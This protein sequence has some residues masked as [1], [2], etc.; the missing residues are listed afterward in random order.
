MTLEQAL[1]YI[2]GGN[3]AASGP[4]YSSSLGLW[5]ALAGLLTI[6]LLVF[7]WRLGMVGRVFSLVCSGISIGVFVI[8]NP[9]P[10]PEQGT[11]FAHFNKCAEKICFIDVNPVG[12]DYDPDVQKLKLALVSGDM[13]LHET[14]Y[15]RND[16]TRFLGGDIGFH[17]LSTSCL[18]TE[19]TCDAFIALDMEPKRD[20]PV[21]YRA[22][23]EALTRYQVPYS[24][25]LREPAKEFQDSSPAIR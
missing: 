20:K 22:D 5:V 13:P 21:I 15:V 19:H 23:L 18:K 3:P 14:P 11:E 2:S 7:L 8:L 25:P 17:V 4:A 9:Y 12:S 16:L 10:Q 6:G 24:L 1:I